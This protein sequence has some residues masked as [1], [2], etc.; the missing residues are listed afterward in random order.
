[1][2]GFKVVRL[3]LPGDWRDGWLYREQLLLW[4]RSGQFYWMPLAGLLDVVTRE[5]TPSLS[6]LSECLLF[7]NDWK[8]GQ[9]FRKFLSVEGV[10]PALLR[11]YRR[12][13]WETSIRLPNVPVEPV[14]SEATP[15]VVLDTSMY[16]NRVYVASTEGLF[17]SYFNPEEPLIRHPVIRRLEVRTAKVAARYL[18]LNASTEDEGLWF[19]PILVGQG[20]WED[21]PPPSTNLDMTRVADYSLAVSFT[22]P[23]LLNYKASPTPGF[24]RAEAVRARSHER[25]LYDEWRILRYEP[26][27]DIER[28]AVYA[29]MTQHRVELTRAEE[30]AASLPDDPPLVLG[31]SGYRLLTYWQD[32]LH[33]V[34]IFA[35]SRRGIEAR[36]DKPF[37]KSN[38]PQTLPDDVLAV[39][40]IAGGFLVEL[41]DELRLV[42]PRASYLLFDGPAARVRTFPRSRRYQEVALVV[43]ENSCHLVGFLEL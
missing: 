18:S 19:A 42:T 2:P 36:P 21:W 6:L 28:L 38:L 8:S 41:F 40:P 3:E 11:D 33:V 25:A 16:A 17:E 20:Y 10:T 30:H 27:R 15:G 4:S 9:L 24:L 13:Q 31:N 14:P 1:V 23:H 32:R 7:R 12:G 26:E 39:Y 43:G 22:S 34:D 29:L 35:D 37:A 5:A